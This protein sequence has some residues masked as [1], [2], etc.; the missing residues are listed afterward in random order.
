MRKPRFV[1]YSPRCSVFRPL[2]WSELAALLHR[3]RRE[4]KRRLPRRS[5]EEA[6]FWPPVTPINCQEIFGT[7][8]GAR[9]GRWGP[10]FGAGGAGGHGVCGGHPSHGPEP[11]QPQPGWEQA[12]QPGQGG[13]G[14]SPSPLS[15]IQPYPS[16]GPWGLTIFAALLTETRYLGEPR[17]TGLWDQPAGDLGDN[18]RN[19]IFRRT[20]SFY[21]H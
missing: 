14:A 10:S 11:P 8:P 12:E 21:D 1:F 16:A 13:R 7:F 5:G 9:G 4:K 15:K 2:Q 17:Q 6:G 3:L 20:G 19:R 18:Q